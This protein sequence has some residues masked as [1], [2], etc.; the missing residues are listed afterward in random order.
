MI[1]AFSDKLDTDNIKFE[2]TSYISNS[3]DWST[4]K[5]DITYGDT[6]IMSRDSRCMVNKQFSDM[7]INYI[8]IKARISTDDTS[9]TTDNGHA[10]V[11]VCN[12]TYIDDKKQIQNKQWHFYPKYEFEDDYISDSAV[13]QVGDN[14]LVKNIKIEIINKEDAQVKILETG[15]KV[16][17][18]I[19]KETISGMFEDP[20]FTNSIADLM[21]PSFEDNISEA[22]D[23][24]LEDKAY[25]DKLMD[26]VVTELMKN[27]RFNSF[28]SNKTGILAI[29]LVDELPDISKVP[30]GYI[31]RLNNMQGGSY[32]I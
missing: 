2:G 17:V 25:M 4:I 1:K 32:E 16:S 5:G 9:I 18:I 23:D 26:M 3:S 31:C 21:L 10:V 13:I 6:I 30:D 8:M 27:N 28:L 12:V 24:K 19:N 7:Q 20:E 22:L 14:I 11:F 15:L 29:P